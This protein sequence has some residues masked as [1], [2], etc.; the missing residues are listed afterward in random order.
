MTDSEKLSEYFKSNKSYRRIMEAL[1]YNFK[2]YGEVK[3]NI[4]LSDAS[5]S[6][7]D[8][9][10]SIITPKKLF[11]PPVLKF[12]MTDFEKGIR[13]SVYSG[14]DIREVL[15]IYFG[16]EIKS[17]KEKK[18]SD[19][20]AREK[21]LQTF[22]N[23][24]YSSPCHKW[25]KAM[26][27]EHKFGYKT[28]I[29]ELT[30][31]SLQAFQ[32]LNYV[33]KAVNS[34]SSKITEPI[35][36]AVLSADITGNSHYFDRNTTS[37]KL[38]IHALAFLSEISEYKNAEQ[39][40]EIYS[41]FSIEPDSISGS[42]ATLGIRLF[43]SKESEHPAYKVFADTG[44]ICLVSS[45]NLM[46][47]KHADSDSKTV[48]AVE[49]QMVFSALT[50]TAVK[51][52]L[53]LLCTSGQVKSAGFKLMDMLIENNCDIYYAGDFDPEGI[54]IAQKLLLRYDSDKFH[55]WRMNVN[56]YR[57]I[58]KSDEEISQTRIKKLEKISSPILKETALMIAECKRAAYQ[59][60]L[61]PKMEADMRKYSVFQNK[62]KYPEL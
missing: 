20:Q 3:G 38:L 34:R 39:V 52:R 59:E 54:Q 48:F 21:F 43:Y 23:K 50:D 57:S 15:E 53:S 19:E 37:G 49:N 2:K 60:L 32:L 31:D 25:I 55:I 11:S 35:Q 8:V 36:L 10:N 7:C 58:E 29:R 18:L 44:E 33:C 5:A 40:R 46:S 45:A 12:K 1:L 9:A 61:I 47:V 16:H 4:L 56:D 26:I 17:N 62:R 41:L 13:N 27:S 30:A 24:Y 42:V 6:E 14:A 51:C 28:L 22:E